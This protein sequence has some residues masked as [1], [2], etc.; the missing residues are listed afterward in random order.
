MSNYSRRTAYKAIRTAINLLDRGF[1]KG[2]YARNKYR[3]EVDSTNPNAVCFC[4]AGALEAACF[5]AIPGRAYTSEMRR[6][7]LFEAVSKAV[8]SNTPNE[9]GTIEGFNDA[10]AT[11]KEDV[12]EVLQW[13]AQEFR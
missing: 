5:R 12:V 1:I 2:D 9:F 8:K 4:A 6:E 11:T 3:H 7:R 13:A 10:V